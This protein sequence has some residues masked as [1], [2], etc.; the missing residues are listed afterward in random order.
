MFEV[1]AIKSFAHNGGKR[2]GDRFRVSARDALDLERKG[3]VE[4]IRDMEVP[5]V[6][7]G[8]KSSASPAD[9]VSPQTTAEP[10]KRG[11]RRKK[12]EESS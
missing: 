3:L 2:R 1:R 12:I 8:A 7:V 6:A 9:P 4:V 10:S 5:R 11:G